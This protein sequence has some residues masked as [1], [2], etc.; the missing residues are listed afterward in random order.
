MLAINILHAF[1]K[2]K[3][4]L[5]VVSKEKELDGGGGE[6]RLSNLYYKDNNSINCSMWK[7]GH[8][9][10]NKNYHNARELSTPHP[11]TLANFTFSFGP[12][13]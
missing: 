6:Q 12:R 11:Q 3:K 8:I 1:L 4:F 2:F 13:I 7:I 9:T 5:C 10:R